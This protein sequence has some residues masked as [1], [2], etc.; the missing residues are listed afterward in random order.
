LENLAALQEP[1]G[2]TK[3]NHK[4]DPYS[5]KEN[6]LRNE[7]REQGGVKAKEGA[8]VEAERFLTLLLKLGNSS[9]KR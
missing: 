4:K 2:D 8:K 6:T 9:L 5:I 1:N 3:Y 7:E